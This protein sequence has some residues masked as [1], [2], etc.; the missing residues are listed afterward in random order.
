MTLSHS[1]DKKKKDL[2]RD[3]ED[4]LQRDP[5]R[6]FSREEILNLLADR[7]SDGEIDKLLA[8]LEVS[9]SLQENKN[10]QSD[11]YAT[12]RGGTVYYRWNKHRQ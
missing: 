2:L 10:K 8:E 3:I 4:V 12:C 1:A 7:E 9:S 11:V 6:M 5:S